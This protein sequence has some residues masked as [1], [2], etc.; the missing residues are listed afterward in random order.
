ML[1]YMQDWKL[2]SKSN[3]QFFVKNG[4]IANHFLNVFE[5]FQYLTKNCESLFKLICCY[6]QFFPLMLLIA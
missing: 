6:L 4:K 3:L 1:V 2:E 5:M